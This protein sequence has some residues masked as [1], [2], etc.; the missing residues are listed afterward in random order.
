MDRDRAEQL[1]ALNA[2]FYARVTD[3]FSQTRTFAWH[4]WD[5]VWQACSDALC[6]A[7]SLLDIGCGNMRFEKFLASKLAHMTD[8]PLKAYAIDSC[9]AL[10]ET[11]SLEGV[12]VDF[13]EMDIHEATR[14]GNAP[15]AFAKI[16]ACALVAC[17]G[18]M[19]HLP[20]ALD[21]EHL[22]LKMIE[23]TAPGGF[24]SVSF[25][26]FASDLRM[27]K[28]AE[29]ATQR[30]SD[31]LGFDID[32][33]QGDYLLDWQNE[34]NAFRFCHSFADLEIDDLIEVACAQGCDLVADYQD[35]GKSGKLNRY[36]IFKV[37]P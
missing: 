10:A 8:K 23:K 33:D 20:C 37:H 35:D 9:R 30:G 21:R 31:L 24:M 6:H 17:F 19:H 26:Q 13:L 7:P 12:L 16:P 1:N 14:D 3:A 27:R 34:T 11:S 15:E 18:L 25:W 4:G 22:L 32:T 5:R 2:N 28:K 36:L 29:R